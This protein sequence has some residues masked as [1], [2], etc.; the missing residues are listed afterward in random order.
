MR[1]I[2]ISEN[3]K[4]FSLKLP[5]LAKH[6]MDLNLSP[7]NYETSLQKKWSKM[8]QNGS[9]EEIKFADG[10]NLVIVDIRLRSARVD[11][12]NE[13]L[14]SSLFNLMASIGGTLG[15]FAGISFISAFFLLLFFGNAFYHL[16]M[17]VLLWFWWNT[18]Q[19]EPEAVQTEEFLLKK[20]RLD[21]R[22]RELKRV[23]PFVSTGHMRAVSKMIQT[24]PRSI[25][26]DPWI[27]AQ[28][29]YRPTMGVTDD[30]LNLSEELEVSSCLF[31][32]G[33]LY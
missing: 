4:H 26:F 14:S 19:G 8:K 2:E 23:F 25:I 28:K 3:S 13:E 16:F 7:L 22:E 31:F 6:M 12:W 20:K 27:A 15:L 30:E 24:E 9:K 32:S 18:F 10:K 21:D 17:T 33:I 1:K 11:T 29:Q 5:L